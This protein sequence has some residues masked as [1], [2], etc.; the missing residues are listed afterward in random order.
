LSIRDRTIALL[1]AVG[2]RTSDVAQRLGITAGRVSQL[3]RT[4]ARSWMDYH[5][6]D[7]ADR[8]FAWMT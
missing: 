7:P 5:G 8:E 6:F 4:L 1:L 2:E 3:R